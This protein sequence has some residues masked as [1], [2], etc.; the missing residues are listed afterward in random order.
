MQTT[1]IQSRLG[2]S[3][4]YLDKSG[5]MVSLPEGFLIYARADRRRIGGSR[6][7]RYY[8][9]VEK[10]RAGEPA[11]PTVLA[12]PEIDLFLCSV[13][14]A[15]P[16][17]EGV[18]LLPVSGSLASHWMEGYLASVDLGEGGV[19]LIVLLDTLGGGRASVRNGILAVARRFEF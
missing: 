1:A 10:L 16:E 2:S 11:L 6:D 9:Y 7:G 12:V 5:R 13:G 15:E 18:S 8:L 14:L 4:L 17:K 3:H 19:Y